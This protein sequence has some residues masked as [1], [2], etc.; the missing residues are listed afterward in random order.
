MAQAK[1]DGIELLTADD[2]IDVL[3]PFL[4]DFCIRGNDIIGTDSTVNINVV[5][6]DPEKEGYLPGY[7]AESFV[8]YGE[9]GLLLGK[10]VERLQHQIINDYMN[11]LPQSASKSEKQRHETTKSIR[12]SPGE[13][14]IEGLEC[15]EIQFHV[16]WE[17]RLIFPVITS[18]F[19]IKTRGKVITFA[20]DDSPLGGSLQISFI[21]T[22]V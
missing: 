13:L 7:N 1:R 15:Q 11:Q 17:T 5:T 9:E 10:L 2:V 4:N 6:H 18:K 14:S 12:F 16:A 19:D 21:S 8:K 3:P 20:T 22:D